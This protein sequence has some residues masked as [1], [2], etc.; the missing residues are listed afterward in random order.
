[1]RY[2]K[3][4]LQMVDEYR[5]F[6]YFRILGFIK[7]SLPEKW[8]SGH[9]GNIIL[10]YGFNENWL[11]LKSIGDRLNREGYKVYAFLDIGSNFYPLVTSAEMLDHF[12]KIKNLNNVTL[13]AHSKGGLIAKLYLD[14][15]DKQKI[16][17]KVITIATPFKGSLWGNLRILNL[18]EIIPNSLFLRDLLKETRNNYKIVSIR[19]QIDNHVIPGASAI[20]P[21]AKNIEVGV[22]GHT[23]I[24]KSNELQKEILSCIESEQN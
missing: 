13:V 8:E 15:F 18:Y 2:L 21:G 17:D 16:V 19:A 6:I 23:R 24:L 9:R 10:I 12:I 3:I 1:M 20:L 11:F 4:L 22:V 5:L 14:R 7:K